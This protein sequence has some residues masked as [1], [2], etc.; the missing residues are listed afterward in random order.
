MPNSKSRFFS[1]RWL[2]LLAAIFSIIAP[3]ANAKQPVDILA[4]PSIVS[5]EGVL[6]EI[7]ITGNTLKARGWAL[8]S[9][10]ANWVTG[11][12]LLI[13]NVEIYSGGFKKQQRPD[14]AQAKGRPDWLE[15]G[16]VIEAT[17]I[18]PL[19]DG[20]RKIEATALLKNGE[21]YDLWVPEEL[22]PVVSST[23]LASQE[24]MGHLDEAVIE[25]D[26]LKVRGWVAISN[27]SQKIQTIL[28]KSGDEILY[29]GKFQIEERPDVATALGKPD[30]INSGW[31]VRLDWSGKPAP[32]SITPHFEMQTGETLSLPLSSAA[33][34]PIAQPAPSEALMG[35]RLAW[36]AAFLL[37]GGVGGGIYRAYQRRRN[38]S[39]SHDVAALPLRIADWPNFLIILFIFAVAVFYK[40]PDQ[41]IN[42][43]FWAEDGVVF[44]MGS[45][46][47]G[48]QSILTPYAGYYHLI[49]RLV[50]YMA[51]FFPIV[52]APAIY[53]YSSYLILL[54]IAWSY[55]QLLN[56]NRS[57]YFLVGSTILVPINGELFLNLTNLQWL[58]APFIL[59]VFFSSPPSGA[60]SRVLL[61]IALLLVCLTG[62]FSI[63]FAPFI[64]ATFFLQKITIYR[65]VNLGI[66]G[67]CSVVQ[68]FSLIKSQ[69]LDKSLPSL[70]SFR[71]LVFNN[72]FSSIFLGK[73]LAATSHAM[74]Y[75]VGIVFLIWI[76]ACIVQLKKKDILVATCL[77]VLSFALL[78]LGLQAAN[79]NPSISP[80][81]VGQRYFYIPALLLIWLIGLLIFKIPRMS[82]IGIVW[83][84]LIAFSAIGSYSALP[85]V[86]YK[87]SQTIKN[88]NRSQIM[89]INPPPWTIS[90]P[91]N[92][93]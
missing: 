18:N 3:A 70:D 41:F 42:P 14:V 22:I 92:A 7:Q 88:P 17:L 40:S 36:L 30:L 60:F 62:P 46:Q 32:S 71:D 49:P 50:A 5:S 26:Q 76:I 38:S 6:D 15:S 34:A 90:I 67:I 87:W 59:V 78:Y 47:Q 33:Q 43:Q 37:A 63:F 16:W 52:A 69:R 11:I 53:L 28:L 51:T 81:T 27:P 29:R 79:N 84:G 55:H 58:I 68:A 73:S 1:P 56:N 19:P 4:V 80:F 44:F 54:V 35:T 25:G 72:Y 10:S 48:F 21:R 2:Y 31:I 20:S 89:P 77:F 83:I 93:K 12:R 24:L 65:F 74:S 13:D 91:L 9:D 23:P 75:V 39:Q 86:D 8:S 66:L 64:V 45:L 85:L 61:S 82:S 57:R